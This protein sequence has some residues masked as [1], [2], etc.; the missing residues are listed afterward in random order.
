MARIE[1]FEDLEVWRKAQD[2]AVSV[3]RVTKKFPSEERFGLTSQIRRSVSSISA[4]I[5]EGFGRQTKKDKLH[6][7][8]IA[9]GSALETKNFLYLAN[10]LDYVNDDELS[11]LLKESVSVQKLLNAFMRPLR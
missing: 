10:R 7:F 8:V 1:S 3:Y 4:N 2:W 5:S 11:E 6:F 9:Y